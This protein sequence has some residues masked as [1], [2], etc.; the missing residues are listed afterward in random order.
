MRNKFIRYVGPVLAVA[1]ILT[2]AV[3]LNRTGISGSKGEQAN[4]LPE[5]NKVAISA[6]A[7]SPAMAELSPAQMKEDLDK[8]V[9][10]LVQMHPRLINDWTNDEQSVIDTAYANIKQSKTRGEFYFIADTIVMLL[11]D[12]HTTLYPLPEVNIL[13]L[14]LF[15][16]REGLL[17]KDRRGA[18]Q[19]GDRITAIGGRSVKDLEEDLQQLIPAENENWVR[20]QAASLLRSEWFLQHLGLVTEGTVLINATRAGHQISESIPLSSDSGQKE[21]N[22]YPEHSAAFT[23]EIKPEQSLGIFQINDCVYSKDYKSMVKRFFDEVYTQG[24]SNIAVD[25]RNN[26]G[27]DS[28]VVEEFLAYTDVR[29]YRSFGGEVRFST[30]VKQQFPDFPED[31]TGK[32][33]PAPVQNIQLT[34]H[35]FNGSVYVLTSPRTF[36]S[37]NWFALIIQDNKLGQIIGE[38][39]GNQPSAYGNVIEFQLQASGIGFQVSFQKFTRPDPSRDPATAVIPD[40]EAYT[41][42]KDIIDRRDAQMEKLYEVI[43]QKQTGGSSS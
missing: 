26:G 16:S 20:T 34:D 39:S 40:I 3:Y 25:L 27:G 30:Q 19:P 31:G 9:Q 28:R 2:A 17:V 5:K 38:A 8:L 1:A 36:S 11:H 24:I 22:P 4:S 10:T 42:A 12:G 6:H 18:F 35:P 43:W 7:P 15:W 13:D 37:A 14:P 32:N 33:E 23:F 21:Y 29:S 41:T